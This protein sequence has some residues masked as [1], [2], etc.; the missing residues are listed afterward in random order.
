MNKFIINE[1][2][3]REPIIYHLS[4]NSSTIAYIVKNPFGNCQ[5]YTIGY[6]NNVLD[7]QQQESI[8]VLKLIQQKIGKSQLL[9]DINN[10]R[11]EYLRRLFPDTEIK[12]NSTYV[13]NTGT[14]MTIFLIHT[15]TI[16]NLLTTKQKEEKELKELE[17]LAKLEKL[18]HELEISF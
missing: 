7:L 4:N 6:F 9:V 12:V 3:V 18:T 2:C 1:I 17:N 10:N 8:D 15:R 14:H 16:P 13:N 5:T 11:I